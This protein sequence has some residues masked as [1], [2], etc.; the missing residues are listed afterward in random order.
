MWRLK[1]KVNGNWTSVNGG[2][3]D[4][5]GTGGAPEIGGLARTGMVEPRWKLGASPELAWGAVDAGGLKS[6][7][8]GASGL[9]LTALGKDL[10]LS[11]R[12]LQSGSKLGLGGSWGGPPFEE[13]LVEGGG[14]DWRKGLK[15]C[16]G[17]AGADCDEGV[18]ATRAGTAGRGEAG[19]E[20]DVTVVEAGRGGTVGEFWEA[21][22]VGG[23]G[24]AVGWGWGWA[25]A[26]AWGWGEAVR[27][28]ATGWVTCG[29]GDGAGL[30][31]MGATW[32]VW[33]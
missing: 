33:T 13:P 19:V 4:R 20:A 22:R 23:E 29:C 5:A 9:L 10:P 11:H 31:A 1:A 17:L 16:C 7:T 30:V 3:Y 15:A 25:W 14:S 6:R 28:G 27:G 32:V 18:A 12:S 8:V 2:S 21:G 24:W 26:W